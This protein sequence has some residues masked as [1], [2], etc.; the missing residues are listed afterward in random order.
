M[1]EAAHVVIFQLMASPVKGQVFGLDA[2]NCPDSM[3]V[4]RKL[5]HRQDRK[6]GI[7]NQIRDG[8]L[9]ATY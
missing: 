7:N 5:L 4:E 9:T 2:N 6:Q 3:A 1:L 8:V